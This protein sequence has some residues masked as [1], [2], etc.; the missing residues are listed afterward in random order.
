M[1][2]KQLLKDYQD[3]AKPLSRMYIAKELR[4]L[5]DNEDKMTS[6][7]RDTYD[8]YVT[9]FKYEMLKMAGDNEPSETRWHLLSKE[10]TDGIIN[11]DI[12]YKF[13]HELAGG[14]KTDIYTKGLRFD[15]YVF[16]SLGF[17]FN[18]D[19]NKEQSYNLN[20]FKL[21]TPDKG[22]I[23]SASNVLPPYSL[24]AMDA[25]SLQSPNVSELNYDEIDA[26][27]SYQIGKFTLS[28]EKSNNIWGYGENG[29][30]IFSNKAPSYPQFKMRVPLSDNIDFVYFHA[31]LNSNVI[32]STLSYYS[33]TPGNSEYRQVD[34]MKYLAAHEIEMMLWNGVDLSIGESVVY[35]DRG[36]SAHLYDSRHVV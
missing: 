35:S 34:H 30:V 5:E 23:S 17:Y 13:S 18:L 28:L 31:E 20:Y 14:V 24:D 9:E 4:E 29:N 33:I 15:G 8:F 2:S 1:S 26:Q 12:D 3:A 27:F 22:V 7:E 10:L 32:D 36:P 11:M 19:D 6:L 25:G 21:N 16:N